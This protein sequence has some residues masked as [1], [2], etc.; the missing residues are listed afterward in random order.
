MS[1]TASP[2]LIP[3]CVKK[4]AVFFDSLAMSANVKILSS[5]LSSHQTSARLF[6]VSFAYLSTISYAKLKFCGAFRRQCSFKS[7]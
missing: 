7:W 4:Y 2:F 3:C 5:S 1:I 6:G